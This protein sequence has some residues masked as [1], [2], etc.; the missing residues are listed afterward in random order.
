M[1]IHEKEIKGK[2]EMIKK[3]GWYM[4]GKDRALK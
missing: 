3:K 4:Q 1:F 2:T